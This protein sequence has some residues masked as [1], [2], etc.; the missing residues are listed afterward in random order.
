MCVEA[1]A[2]FA[3]SSDAHAPDQVG[4]GYERRSSSSP[5]WASTELCVFERPR[6]PARAPGGG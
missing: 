1:G 6:A 2:P 3:L 5:T 4:F